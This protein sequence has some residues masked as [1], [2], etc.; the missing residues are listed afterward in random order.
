MN[1][2]RR[3]G[4]G[5]EEEEGRV[6]VELTWVVTLQLKVLCSNLVMLTFFSLRLQSAV[7]NDY[8]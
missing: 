6:A 5:G 3:R 1:L 7:S 8:K 2:A 4:R